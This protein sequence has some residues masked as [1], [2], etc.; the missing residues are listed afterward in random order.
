MANERTI[1]WN[2]VKNGN[3][4]KGGYYLVTLRGATFMAYYNSGRGQ[5]C[6]YSLDTDEDKA[7]IRYSDEGIEAWAELPKP[8]KA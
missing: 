8:F 3:P 5:K 7:P 1:T 6:W 4:K 2:D